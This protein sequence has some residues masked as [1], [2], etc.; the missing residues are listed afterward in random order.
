[1]MDGNRSE[2]EIANKVKAILDSFLD[3]MGLELY[4]IEYS[5]S[6]RMLRV[7]IDRPRAGVTIDDC[8]RVSRRLSQELDAEDLISQNYR[9]EVSSPGLDRPLKK[10]SDF[11]KSLG[12]TARIFLARPVAQKMEL[13]GRILDCKDGMVK[14]EMGSGEPLWI[15]LSLINKAR[16]E[17]ER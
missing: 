11:R 7:F 12:R 5:G 9:L 16:Q 4:D 3:E 17:L 10:E 14:L 8:A 1:M 6:S 2:Q 15:P 13:A